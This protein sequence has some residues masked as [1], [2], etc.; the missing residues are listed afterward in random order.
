MMIS[1]EVKDIKFDYIISSFSVLDG[2]MKVKDYHIL[3]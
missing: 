2:W 1:E 3:F